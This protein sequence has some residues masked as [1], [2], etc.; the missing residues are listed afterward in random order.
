MIGNTYLAMIV[1]QVCPVLI[2]QYLIK[3]TVLRPVNFCFCTK[4]TDS[5]RLATFRELD[6][7]IDGL[8]K[9]LV[10]RDWLPDGLKA[11]DTSSIPKVLWRWYRPRKDARVSNRPH[12]D[13]PALSKYQSSDRC[14]DFLHQGISEPRY[15]K[16]KSMRGLSA[17]NVDVPK[18][19]HCLLIRFSKLTGSNALAVHVKLYTLSKNTSLSLYVTQIIIWRQRFPTWHQLNNSRRV[20]VPR[21][22]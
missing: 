8:G 13:S 7:L 5:Y 9:L 18:I 17:S 11:R 21:G 20:N 12:R 10:G 15:G 16:I 2:Q 4:K 3:Q 14:Y 19:T 6:G 22:V 1:G